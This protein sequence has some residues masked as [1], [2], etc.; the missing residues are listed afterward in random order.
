MKTTHACVGNV[1]FL[2][3]E[4]FRES[5]EI[6]PLG[7]WINPPVTFL[8]VPGLSNGEYAQ[9]DERVA[10]LKSPRTM[11]DYK[12]KIFKIM[13]SSCIHSRTRK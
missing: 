13:Y 10:I 2:I 6:Y 1:Y 12:I 7:N 8:P 9:G 4:N 3:V 11:R 5:R